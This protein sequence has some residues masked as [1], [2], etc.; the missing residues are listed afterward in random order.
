[1][2]KYI[3]AHSGAS[4]RKKQRELNKSQGYVSAHTTTEKNTGGLLE[5][6]G[7]TAGKLG[8]G[9]GG[10]VEGVGDIVAAGGDLIRGDTEM[11]EYRFK[12]NMTGDASNKLDEWYN[13]GGVMRFVGD[14][15][16]GIGQSSVFLLDAVAPGLGT[17]LFF[18]GVGGQNVASAAEQTGNVGWR[19]LGYGA[20][21]AGLEAA[22]GK[23]IGAGGQA[24][25]Q[26]GGAI[27]KSTGKT[28]AKKA[29]QTAVTKRAWTSV[30][31]E[32]LKSAIGEGVEEGVSEVADTWLLKW[33]GIDEDAETS[34][35][36]VLYAAGV[37]AVSGGLMTAG[38]AA[39]NYN[40]TV[41]AGR[42]VKE[43]GEV[44]ILLRR[45]KNAV[46]GATRAENRAKGEVIKGSDKYDKDANVFS[47]A[48]SWSKATFGVNRRAKQESRQAKQIRETLEKNITGYENLSE[49]VRN[50]EGGDALLGN[51]LGNVYLLEN[52]YRVDL[53]EELMTQATPEMKQA[54]VDD[55]NA[56]AKATGQKKTDY[57]V[58]DLDNDVDGI[59]RTYASS[60]VYE[61][62]LEKMY[63]VENATE[64]A[65]EAQEGAEKVEDEEVSGEVD[66]GAP[67]DIWLPLDDY[68][69]VG[70]Y[71]INNEREAAL[72]QAAKRQGVPAASVPSMLNIFRQDELSPEDFA[73]GWQQGVG[74]FG[75]YNVTDIPEKSAL[76]RMKSYNRDAAFQIGRALAS[77]E[78]MRREKK[79][80]KKK[81]PAKSRGVDVEKVRVTGTGA[82]R[83]QSLE[84]VVSTPK[85]E[86]RVIKEKG[87][88]IRD[89]GE[90]AYVVY[91]ASELM[92][93]VLGT[94]IHIHKTLGNRDGGKING[95]YDVSDNTIHID[96]DAGKD[97]RGTALFTLAHEVTHYIREWSPAKF[98]AISDFVGERMGADMEGLMTR[99]AELLRK[100]PQFK[101]KTVTE[102]NDAAHEEVIADAMETILSNGTVMED[103]ATY[104]KSIW[105]KVKD[106]I[107]DLI[108]KIK[109]AYGE[110]S[111]NS[112]AA[113][114]LKDTVDDM[115]EIQ[116][117]WAEGVREAGERT[118]TAAVTRMDEEKMHVSGKKMSIRAEYSQEIEEWHRDGR[119]DGESFVLGMTG[120]VLQG[121]GAIESDIYINGD[122]IK[123]ILKD[124]PE[125]TLEEIKKI[126]QILED[127]VLIL[128][129]R[130]VGRGGQMNS[131]MVIFGAVKAENGQP[132][133]SVLDLHPTEN[134]FTISDMQ[135]VTSAYTKT[136]SPV[137]FVKDSFI[138]YA[139]KK[140]T[141]SL[142]RSIGFQM[143]IELNKSGYIGSISYKG[144]SV[145]IF[146]E[147]FSA[148]FMEGQRKYSI[149]DNSLVEKYP[150]L[151]L[152]QDISNMNGVP[153]IQLED[154]SVLTFTEPHVTFIQNNSI[155]VEDIRSGGW[156]VDGVYEPSE[157]SDTL[158]YKER[159]LAKKRMDEKRAAK[160]GD[161][162][163][164]IEETD[165]T[166]DVSGKTLADYSYTERSPWDIEPI[167]RVTS[168]ELY[169]HLVEDFEE[170]GYNGRPI[171]ALDG[172]AITGSHRLLAA[173]EA[174]IDIPVVELAVAENHPLYYEL[175]DARD[176]ITRAEI[177]K[178]LLEDGEITQ[179]EYD[180]IA[181]EDEL[182]EEN[183][184]RSPED[185]VRYSIEETDETPAPFAAAEARME[186]EAAARA[187]AKT[188]TDTETEGD[189][190]P[191]VYE[192]EDETPLEAAARRMREREAEERGD[193]WTLEDEDR[194]RQA[195][196]DHELLADALMETA[197]S[198]SEYRTVK[199]Y[200]EKVEEIADAESKITELR[201][202]TAEL[203][204]EMDSLRE[205]IKGVDKSKREV[206]IMTA[207]DDATVQKDAYL[208]EMDELSEM[209]R[210]EEAKLLSLAAAKPLQKAIRE[211]NKR[212]D[213]MARVAE[214]ERQRA[215]EDRERSRERESKTRQKAEESKK[216]Y[217]EKVDEQT[218]Q[219]RERKQITVRMRAA[220]KIL[221]SLNRLLYSPTKEKH[222]PSQLH[223][224]TETVLRSA[225]P[226]A[227][228]RNR[229]NIRT[230]AELADKIDKLE[231]KVAKTAEE[232]E[233]LD[234][235]KSKYGHLEEETISTKRQAEALLTAFEEYQKNT[236]DEA[237][238]DQALID[239]LREEVKTIEE[240]PLTEMTL[241]SLQA[242]EDFYTKLKHQVDF[243]NKTFAT[244][245][246]LNIDELGTTANREVVDQKALKFLSPK[247]M[248]MKGKAGVREYFWKNM[249]PLTAFEAIGSKQFSEL[250]QNVLNG[251][252]V[253]ITDI[254]EA[255]EFLKKA[256]KEY[257][258]DK[259][260]LQARTE[261]KTADGKKV[262]LT[263]GEKLSLYAY[264]F[265]DQAEAHLREGGFTF[266]P[267]ATAVQAFKDGKIKYEAVLN[268][269]EQHKMRKEDIAEMSKS[270]T[271]E[272]KDFAEAVQ[273]YLTSLGKKGNQVSQKLYGVDL[274]NETAYFPIR[275]NKDYLKAS[276]G[277][278]GDPN[279][280]NRGSFKET[281]P[282]ASNPIVLQDF[283]SVTTEHINSMATYHAFV[284]PLEDLTRVWN[285][286]PANIKRDEDGKPILDQNGFP[287]A[288]D[289]DKKK[290]NSL[291]A[292][293]TK[294]YGQEA[295]DY[296]LQL[297]RDLNGG[298]RRD[299]AATILDKGITAFKRAS[300]MASLSVVIQQPTSLFRA[301][302]YLKGKYFTGA[303][304]F[305]W[306]TV[307][308]YAPVAGIK[309]MGGFDTGTGAR[310]SEFLNAREYD[311]FG[312][313]LRAMLKPK[314]YGGDPQARAEAFGW[315]AGKADE[316]T[317]RY[318]FGACVNEQAEL[319]KKE[320]NSEE[321]LKAAG[322]RFTEI[323]R[324]T[325]VYDSTLTRS[326]YMR[327]KDGLM[328]MATAFGSEP[329]TVVSMVADGIIRAER[330]DKAFLARTA[331]GV[332]ASILANAL[333]VSLIYAIRDDD[334][335]KTFSEKYMST[336]VTESLEGINPLEY[337]P[338]ARDVMSIMK[339]YDVERSDMA[340]IGQLV[341]SVENITSSKKSVP[342]KMMEVSGAVS[343][344]FGVPLKNI[345][346]DARGITTTVGD[347]FS[348]SSE[349]NTG[350]GMAFAIKDEFA[351]INK[352]F[353][354]DSSNGYQ[355]YKAILSGDEAHY[356][357]VAAR[358]STPEAAESALRTAM[359]EHDE[360]IYE[361]AEKRNAGDLEGYE[362]MVDK[363]AS[364]G[365]FDRNLIIQA[366]RNESYE[367][368]KIAEKQAG[369]NLAPEA[370]P[371]DDEADA[372]EGLYVTSDMTSAMERGDVG[373]LTAIIEQMMRDKV[374][375]GKT[376]K[377]AKA[378]LRSAS[379]A[380]WKKRY[381]AAW[382]KNDAA[383]MRRIRDALEASG[384]YGGYNDMIAAVRSW[385]QNAK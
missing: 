382:E 129:S 252:E 6:I 369:M 112:Q 293:I 262:S 137:Q 307:K 310:T 251:E 104:D 333:L 379:T 49:A 20:A 203:N 1:M 363:L 196:R 201:K 83:G 11:A 100:M 139:D 64:T 135:K 332:A 65:E 24:T 370:D 318:M 364:E 246:A 163:Y 146:G 152:N 88:Y 294:K 195:I 285:Y 334:E 248:E 376:E 103:L 249:K 87:V 256:K 96:L 188:K 56:K 136:T 305:D 128:K 39:I 38:P 231:R 336:L 194:R 89:E 292:E 218:K 212:A 57:T 288:E 127:P 50:S 368:K 356:N 30:G 46:A 223:D 77:E 62:M 58:Q 272:Q 207:L 9:L 235:M 327:S 158:R 114:V 317:W 183:W 302:A 18:A 220:Q 210:K 271:Q 264:M 90:G 32:V 2:S 147:K 311:N 29:A 215:E 280:K 234:K 122:K 228:G 99:K 238:F 192:I 93:K 243:A 339:G 226:K 282:D 384:L 10:V 316:V 117:L 347:F 33:F 182:N 185:A 199:K 320:R 142:L 377:E 378:S 156:I 168:K 174:G 157:R 34:I 290:Y 214:K 178:K 13:P 151:N 335:E 176:D 383:E 179:E 130:N 360:R 138:V 340:L 79:A 105:E 341:Q 289:S 43:A 261:V 16:S 155:D 123:E 265:R 85:T 217:K 154:G 107:V 120:D 26:L 84:E 197:Q 366:I 21:S 222:V 337:L 287:I 51:M 27:L 15:A 149:D 53:T 255:Y 227:F 303:Q 41:K 375:S 373:D 115:S 150:N 48:A 45:A 321:V 306:E 200:K 385:I 273:K 323:V 225:D 324:R 268:D 338:I 278:S 216:K 59:R 331:G 5:G 295:N 54:F 358:F 308:K 173:R 352:L 343:S 23:F 344:F 22:V 70:G 69:A 14:T 257:G 299:A 110:L 164:S 276:T 263:L 97:A 380:Y 19:E 143:P 312:Q 240:A 245:R 52:A 133:M 297:I 141:A 250:F 91:K 125:M 144:R 109:K 244:E 177:A 193:V 213:A 36:Q 108:K 330:G 348:D 166:P 71:G 350:T 180:L 319:L 219:S 101:D 8:L 232:Q 314:I 60:A 374:D 357:R 72:L 191:D 37:G 229:D 224:L 233:S 351:F 165:E 63:G 126:P 260:D 119:P 44:D 189:E 121:L 140:R 258:F 160:K 74:V 124:H 237:T 367:L 75:R 365:K 328:K 354:L 161:I 346:R 309:E 275:S 259:W 211:A 277:K 67:E 187:E 236:T 116:R 17:G 118:R 372:A 153:A 230:M 304:M 267:N 66:T 355:M 159:M 202:K 47:R 145:N 4:Y 361:A 86:G 279:I 362:A 345:Y 80:E 98:E 55:I 61:M 353:G 81:A 40:Q 113:K 242:V 95:Y 73:E 269:Q 325:Q 162:R 94:D 281:V 171:V 111:P 186:A 7:Y 253:W 175:I 181:R 270:L 298:A 241:K 148:V 208:K 300:T 381:I 106:F 184:G 167:N 254:M 78:A 247:S 239:A 371:E 12:D 102:L 206:W 313:K 283:M 322:K 284:L 286:T 25:K 326:E 204:R 205:K 296:I 131:R 172:Q 31:K 92:A 68:E 76:G 315:L 169:R 291:K 3:S 274:F 82:E 342:D 221:G 28:A 134:N 190:T 170:N 301:M 198:E 266:A 359:R 35:G 42:A 329:T 132:V 209:I 349:K